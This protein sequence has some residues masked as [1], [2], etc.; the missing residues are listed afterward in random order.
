M[1]TLMRTGNYDGVSASGDATLRLIAAGDVAPVN[2]DLTPNY[3]NVFEGLKNQAHNTVD[4]VAYGVPHGR[5]AN[6]MFWNTDEYGE[7]QTSW[8]LVSSPTLPPP[9]RSRCSISRSRSRTPP[10]I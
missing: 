6:L 9:G 4:G 5:G 10:C 2:L 3:E 1:V 7:D 8:G